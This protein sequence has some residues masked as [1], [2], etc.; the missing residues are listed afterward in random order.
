MGLPLRVRLSVVPGR[1]HNLYLEFFE[2]PPEGVLY[3]HPAADDVGWRPAADERP[4][5]L[6]RARSSAWVKRAYG[7][8]LR[9]VLG[10]VGL[11]DRLRP[12]AR[13]YDVYHSIGSV[14]PM[15]EPWVVTLESSLDFFSFAPGMWRDEMA[16]PSSR[17]F[18]RRKLLSRH[19][20]R[21]LPEN[22]AAR[23]SVLQLF[24][25]H[26]REL[27][28][29]MEVVY[30]ALRAGPEPPPE[31]ETRVK[32][33][34]FVGSRNFPKDF[35][36]KGGHLVLATYE[37]LRRERDDV[38]LVVR[39][40]VPDKYRERYAKL[41]GLTILDG[42]LPREQ[43]ERL[44]ADSHVFLFP[45]SSTPGMV[46][47]E[48]MRAARPVVTIDVWGNAEMVQ[49]GVTGFVCPPPHGV[50]YVNPWGGL[51]WS[52][53]PAFLGP[54][55]ANVER[56][57]REMTDATRRLLDDAAMRRRFGQAARREI[58]SG[59]LSI[60]ARNAKLRAIYEDAAR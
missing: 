54:F 39:A 16:K 38:E 33:L 49:H 8:V 41:P 51:N 20:R 57:V 25:D 31:P 13:E 55:E 53:E 32:R 11:R 34:L 45:G 9:H 15:P 36:P 26:K 35:I 56:T 46:I 59:K 22:E 50:E 40:V 2:A 47:R 29:K 23:R 7:P 17:A 24:P 42:E 58:V 10:G 44:Y 5:L 27:E 28:E 37:A 21:I 1:S 52:H 18:V 60:A 19:C 4:S 48:A 30:M 6:H 12:R 43:V 3:S 14:H